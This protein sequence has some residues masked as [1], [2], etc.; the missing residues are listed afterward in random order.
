MCANLCEC[1]KRQV[2]NYRIDKDDRVLEIYCSADGRVVFIGHYRWYCYAMFIADPKADFD[3]S[4]ILKKLLYDSWTDVYLLSD[5]KDLME[6]KSIDRYLCFYMHFCLSDGVIIRYTP[7][8]YSK[9]ACKFE[10]AD[11][12]IN[13]IN[14]EIANF[15]NTRVEYDE[16]GVEEEL[17]KLKEEIVNYD[18][19]RYDKI[20]NSVES[21]LLSMQYLI[22]GSENIRRLYKEC[23]AQD[24]KKYNAWMT[25][26]R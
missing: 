1:L 8:V 25:V 14:G 20:I 21:K 18:F 12:C 13:Y 16:A 9:P 10:D 23:W 11:K 4:D 17:K 2:P 7:E 5:A 26:A 24:K 22:F 15:Y 19:L 6:D 3:Y